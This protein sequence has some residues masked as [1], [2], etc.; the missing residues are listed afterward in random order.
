MLGC[1]LTLGR[2]ANPDVHLAPSTEAQFVGELMQWVDAYF[3]IDVKGDP[4]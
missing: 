4:N 2:L 1:A 3:T